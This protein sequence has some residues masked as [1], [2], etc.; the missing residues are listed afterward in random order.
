MGYADGFT[1]DASVRKRHW[2]FDIIRDM[3]RILILFVVVGLGF[4]LCGAQVYSVPEGE[5]RYPGYTVEVDGEKAPVS[6][7]RCSAMPFNRRW[8]GH[9]RQIEQTELCGMVRFSFGGQGT[10][11]PAKATVTVT[12]AKDFKTVKIRPL[13]RNVAFHRKGRTVTFDIQRPGGYSVEFDGYHNNLHVFADAADAQERVPP[14]ATGGLYFGPG[15]HEIGIRQLKS[16]ETVYLDP[17][18]IVFG[19]FHASNATDIAILGRGILDMSRIKEKILFP[20][21]GDGHEAVKNA[22]RWHTIDFKN[23]RNVKIDGIVIRDSLCYNIAMWGCEDVAVSGVKIIGQWRFNT[24]GIDLHNCRRARVTDCFARTF[25]DTFCFKAHEG[26]GNCEDCS[27]ERC[28]AWNDWGK[29]FEVGVECRADHLRRLAFR[30]CDC[31]HAVSWPMDVSNVDYGRVSDVTFENIRIESD[32]PMPCS[33]LQQN[34]DSPFDP[35][36]GLD[37][38]PR[39]FQG[40][41][42]F[43]HEYSR[44]NGGKWRGGG[45]IDGVAVRDVSVTTDGRK[46]LIRL[47]AIDAQHRPENVVFE[48]MT[49]NGKPVFGADGVVLE[50]D[51]EKGAVPPQFRVSDAK[52]MGAEEMNPGST[53]SCRE[54]AAGGKFRVLIYGNSIA[55]HGRAPKIGWN[56]DWGMAASAREKDFAH[57]VVAELEA[58]R[59]ERADYRIRN[60]A[61]LERNFRT[62]LTHFADLASDV[63]YAPDYVVIAIGENVPSIGEKDAPDYTRFLVTLAKP[64]VESA[65]R[66]RVVMRSP[67]WRNAVKADCTATAAAEVGATYVDA[68]PLGEQESN[69]ALGLFE[70]KGVARH[71]GDL[72]MRRLAELILSGFNEGARYG[73]LRSNQTAAFKAARSVWPKG[74]ET[75]MNDFIEFRASFDA[76]EE[77]GAVLRITGS[78]VYRIWLNGTFVGYGPARAAKG[79]FRM[80]EWPLA[81]KV[82]R[83]DLRIEVSAYNCNNFYIPEQPP[84]I[85]AE[86]VAG[87]RVL[88]A[89]GAGTRDACPYHTDFRAY[90]TPRVTKCSRYSYQRAFGEAYRLGTAAAWGHTSLPGTELPL[91][92]RPSVRVIERIAA[93]PKFEVI[94]GLK[95]ISATEVSWKEPATFRK[96]R[97]IDDTKPWVK[98][99]KSQDLDVNLWRELQC[100]SVRRE[101]GRAD[102]CVGRD[103]RDGSRPSL[104]AGHGVQY[105]AGIN[106][107]GFIG[108]DVECRKAGT[109][110]VA[111]DEILME[112][113]VNPLRYTVCNAVRYDM[114]P[115]KYRIENFEPYTFRYMHIYTVDGDGGG[116]Q[117]AARPTG[118]GESGG[119][120]AARPTGGDFVVSNVFVRTY[121]SPAADKASFKSSDAA[122]DGVFKAAKETFAQNAVDVFTDCPG[123]ERAGWLCD[124]FFLG[125]SSVLLTGSTDLERLFIQNY[126][127]PEKFDDMPDGMLPMCYPSDHRSGRYIPNW[128]M[129]FVIQVGEYLERSGDRAT[130]DALRPRLEKLVAFLWNYR[131]AD[132]LL[133]KLPSWVFIEWSKAND[134]VQDVSYPSNATWAEVL[135]AMDRMYG[136]PD[137]AAEAQRVRETVRRQSWTGTWFCDNAVRQKDGT[138]KPSGHCTETC[139]YYMFMFGVATKESHPALWN[140]LLTEFGPD[141]RETKKHPEI[142]FANAF[143]GNYLRLELLSRAGLDR[144][145]I[146]ETKGYFSYMAERTGTLWEFVS[147]RNSCNHGFTSYVAVLYAKSLLGVEKIDAC[148]KTVT[149]RETDVPLEFCEAT[150]PVPGGEVTIGWRMAGG[151]RKETFRA[152]PGWTLRRR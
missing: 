93:Y 70:H 81:A 50:T 75:R 3:K 30:D 60:L 149:V 80:D 100:A 6:E 67:F 1:G 10:S 79:F 119:Q 58:K 23:C 85:Q 106:T 18:A 145:L 7:V 29:A 27:F 87:D 45:F 55:L 66:P 15:F 4:P 152:P 59:G 61:L 14:D 57:L 109:L 42:N 84:F 131:N 28:V 110:Y 73:G 99:Y 144:Q 65:K 115:G 52:R 151:E 68:G 136:R 37:A 96:A 117:G 104:V 34:D 56:A 76:K 146:D 150:L 82:G 92:E 143:I 72:G 13:S 86:I 112:G 63:A 128:A 95:P 134:Y 105:D 5:R 130:V 35:N 126:L 114:T 44:E 90:E 71:P 49:V 24:D 9:Q 22:K 101:T 83:N 139:Q 125:R 19:G 116:G 54:R 78:S 11:R 17:G 123:R 107:T 8:P 140:T 98:C 132:G 40:L 38:P 138:L 129:W 69:M 118:G 25:D 127:L 133:E 31:I 2:A 53:L 88:A 41:V 94:D 97:W 148:E 74:R 64:L 26:S 137:L 20:A 51:T 135:D 32:E 33:Q 103:G 21:T 142:A 102:L 47:G 12:A 77:R 120:G 121:R 122:I 108:L 16:G 46:P 147:D 113:V 91:A 89:T 111:F 39:C 36:K 62:N 141:R 43:H 48:D 124:S